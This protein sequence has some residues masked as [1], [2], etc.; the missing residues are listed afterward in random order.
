VRNHYIARDLK[1]DCAILALVRGCRAGT[2][3]RRRTEGGVLSRTPC[4]TLAL[5]PEWIETVQ[6]GWN[7]C[8]RLRALRRGKRRRRI[9]E[10]RASATVVRLRG[11]PGNDPDR[12]VV[13]RGWTV[14][15]RLLFSP[16]FKATVLHAT[17]QS[18]DSD[19]NRMVLITGVAGMLGS[20]LLDR[21]MEA[22]GYDV[23]GIGRSELRQVREHLA[24]SG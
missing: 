6:A 23:V 5:R 20:H 18:K 19:H 15:R 3:I 1:G 12:S 24:A 9:R 4:V 7:R 21:L 13:G 22:G 11:R 2:T 16:L 8:R 14:S 17:H 10:S